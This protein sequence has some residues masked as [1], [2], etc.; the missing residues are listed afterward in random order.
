MLL[1]YH[2]ADIDLLV[3]ATPNRLHVP[4]ARRALTHRIAVVMDKPLAPDLASAQALVDDFATAG[5]PFTVF[6]N[7]RWDVDFLTVRRLAESGDLGALTRFESRYERFRPQVGDGSWRELPG[8]ADG[9]GLLVDDGTVLARAE[10]PHPASL[11]SIW[12]CA[13]PPHDACHAGAV[14][15]AG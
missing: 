7:R 2:A 14:R 5:V 10:M 9:G 1:R 12:R 3:V 8:A 13:P 6:Q 11:R 15:L 4:I